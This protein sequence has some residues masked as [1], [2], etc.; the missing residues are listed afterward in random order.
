MAG[1]GKAL[2]LRQSGI[3][4][5]NLLGRVWADGFFLLM[6]NNEQKLKLNH[7]QILALIK[8]LEGRNLAGKIFKNSQR[9]KDG[10]RRMAEDILLKMIAIDENSEY[11]KDI[12]Q[13]L[14]M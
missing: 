8:S 3:C 9:I 2:W 7:D 13:K 12:R 4:G 6:N 5:W 11:V 14:R 10:W 1:A